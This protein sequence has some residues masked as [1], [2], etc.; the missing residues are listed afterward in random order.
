VGSFSQH[1]VVEETVAG[2]GVVTA[3]HEPVMVGVAR[4]ERAQ[5]FLSIESG[6]DVLCGAVQSEADVATAKQ[7]GDLRVL[8]VEP[9]PVLVVASGDLGPGERVQLSGAV[10]GDVAHLGFAVHDVDPNTGQAVGVAGDGYLFEVAVAEP[11]AL[12]L[13]DAGD[14]NNPVGGRQVVQVGAS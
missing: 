10:D 9:P 7:V 1:R 6:S 12:G 8:G 13:V 5:E 4:W 11:A 3:A 14:R 2:F